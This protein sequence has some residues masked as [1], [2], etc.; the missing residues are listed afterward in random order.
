MQALIPPHIAAERLGVSRNT[1]LNMA[2]DGRLT[3]V[4]KV[5]GRL[6]AY[7]FDEAQIDAIAAGTD[8]APAPRVDTNPQPAVKR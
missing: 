5:E 6:G 7:L 3:P 1:I 4:A 8:A 2:R